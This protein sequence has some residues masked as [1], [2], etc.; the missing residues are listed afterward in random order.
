MTSNLARFI[1]IG[2][3]I[4]FSA[5]FLAIMERVVYDACKATWKFIDRHDFRAGLTY[6]VL[7]AVVD[8][9]LWTNRLYI[10]AV[11]GFAVF[12][13]LATLYFETGT[14]GGGEYGFVKKRGLVTDT[15]KGPG[16]FLIAR[17]NKVDKLGAVG[18]SVAF[19]D[20]EKGKPIE[21]LS[22][23]GVTVKV[24]LGAS[25]WLLPDGIEAGSEKAAVDKADA[26]VLTARRALLVAPAAD[27]AAAETKVA[28]AEEAMALAQNLADAVALEPELSASDDKKYRTSLQRMGSSDKMKDRAR[29]ILE[30]AVR[31]AVGSLLAIQA[32]TTEREN[33]R[34]LIF[35]KAAPLLV[36]AQ[37]DL[38]GILLGEVEPENLV[39][40]HE[41]SMRHWQ[42]LEQSIGP[43]GLAKHRIDSLEKAGVV[44][45]PS[46][47]SIHVAAASTRVPPPPPPTSGK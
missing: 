31:D 27:V 15:W 33:L 9:T 19:P 12:P 38:K 8:G 2:S 43:K 14:L 21:A 13:F 1:L 28:E 41:I 25:F 4:S 40:L 37:I 10:P 42:G 34:Q 20:G 29:P 35:D 32:A 18:H 39:R 47:P 26:A 11:I 36:K 3:V 23:D 7:L 24:S 46:D 22:R 45:V 6:G 5:L 30:Q 16:H 44:V 17:H